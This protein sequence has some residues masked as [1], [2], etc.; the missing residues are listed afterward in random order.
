[1][2][3]S[4]CAQR[5][6]YTH[7]STSNMKRDQRWCL[8]M[9]NVYQSPSL[10]SIS[11]PLDPTLDTTRGGYPPLSV[12]FSHSTTR[13]GPHPRLTL[14]MM[15]GS[16]P[17]SAFSCTQHEGSH[18]PFSFPPTQHDKTFPYRPVTTRRGSSTKMR[19]L[20][21]VPPFLYIYI[22]FFYLIYFFLLKAG[23]WAKARPGQ[24]RA[25]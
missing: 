4:F 21:D 9:F 1:M 18:S 24:A 8:F 5:L 12:F 7:W 19:V 16:P 13:G 20:K 6:F 10:P 17:L 2:L 25:P 15:R 23:A 22:T 11:M 14:D 3:V